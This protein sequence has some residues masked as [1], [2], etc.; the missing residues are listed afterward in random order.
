MVDKPHVSAA[1]VG[2]I[3]SKPRTVGYL[4][5]SARLNFN[6]DLHGRI[7]PVE[8]PAKCAK[9]AGAISFRSAG[10]TERFASEDDCVGGAIPKNRGSPSQHAKG[11]D[12]QLKLHRR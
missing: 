2:R 12:C 7:E 6:D 3:E 10:K 8:Q 9:P 11:A 5:S 4:R 1:G